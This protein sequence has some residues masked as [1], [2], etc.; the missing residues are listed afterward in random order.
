MRAHRRCTAPMKAPRP[1]PTMPSRSGG[2]VRASDVAST[3]LGSPPS[4]DA[5]HAPIGGHVGAGT[6]EIVERLFRDPDDRSEEH[7]SELQSRFDLVCR[8]LLEKKKC[9]GET[10]NSLRSRGPDGTR[11]S[12]DCGNALSTISRLKT[13]RS[14]RPKGSDRRVAVFVPRPRRHP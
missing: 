10:L 9:T 11:H 7:T 4:G 3:M 8:L 6:G 1:P 2:D 12:A 13:C 5:E 14:L